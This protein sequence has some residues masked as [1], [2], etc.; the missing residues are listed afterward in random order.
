MT[1]TTADL[2]PRS[3]DSLASS[4][5]ID[6]YGREYSIPD[7]NMK[8]VY[9]AI[10]ARCFKRSTLRGLSYVARDLCM[11][12]ATG[13]A[14]YSLIPLLPKSFIVRMAAWALYSFIQGCICTGVWVLAHECGHN[15]FSPSNRINAVVGWI[16]HSALLVPFFSW[17]YSHGKH[18]K[19]TGHLDKDMVFVPKTRTYKIAAR[20]MD[21]KDFDQ[22][23]EESESRFYDLIEETPLKTFIDVVK[24][25][26]FGWPVYLFTNATGG[27]VESDAPAWC[28]N[29][30]VPSSPLFSPSQYWQIVLSDVGL[31]CTLFALYSTAQVVGWWNVALYYGVPYLWVNHWLVLITFLQH[32]DPALPHY[33]DAAWTF[34]RGA[35]ATIDRDFGFIGR[36]V[37]HGIIETHVSHHLCSRIPFYHADEATKAV[38]KV[39]AG[40]YQCDDTNIFLAAWRSARMCQWIE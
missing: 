11:V 30:F 16:L 12:F 6:T 4:R 20:G 36:H 15:A 26:L 33:R 38:R 19:A 28:V 8:E 17:K 21:P 37:F 32:T 35:A 10:P 5:Y 13:Y 1:T 9:E 27:K 3:L 24:Q 25:Q 39:M 18:H 23:T 7:F 31:F 2:H 40:A 22:G 34:E 14:A 29:H